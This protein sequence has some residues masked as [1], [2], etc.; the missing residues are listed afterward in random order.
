MSDFKP[1]NARS[2]YEYLP[3]AEHQCGDIWMDLPSFGLIGSLPVT[4]GIMITPSCDVANFKTETLTYLPVVP[5]STYLSTL[6]FLPSVRREIMERFRS[7]DIAPSM[8]LQDPGY[9]PPSASEIDEQV[10]FLNAYLIKVG[11]SSAKRGH[12]ERA[13]AGLRIAAACSSAS[14]LRV[15]LKDVEKLMGQKW[16]DMKFGII[17]NS[18]RSDL[19]FLPKS[20]M[21]E[22]E[23][24]IS[25]H[26]L[27]LFRYPITVPS[28]VLTA[29]QSVPA[30]SWS[31]FI[32]SYRSASVAASA[33][34]SHMPLKIACLKSTFLADMLSRFTGLY[35]RV[36]SPDFT[37]ITANRISREIT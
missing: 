4:T 34:E 27:V 11:L 18:Y 5:V 7:A 12:I 9:Q 21:D 14:C 25:E 17:R 32:D 16:S 26:S 33:F 29:S 13:L 8:N 2:Y 15:D 23:A 1:I 37:S 24:G 35:S 20:T 22:N 28:E 19:H 6:G 36:G 31:G 30:T 10:D 3:T